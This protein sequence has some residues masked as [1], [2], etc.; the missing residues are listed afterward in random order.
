MA[1][2]YINDEVIKIKNKKNEIVLDCELYEIDYLTT[3]F[4][5]VQ[6]FL[7]FAYKSRAISKKNYESENKNIFIKYKGRKIVP[8]FEDDIIRKITSDLV[9]RN[10]KFIIDSDIFT[11][12]INELLVFLYNKD[13]EE[14]IYKFFENDVEV[15]SAFDERHSIE[16]FNFF[17]TYDD[18][19]MI[20]HYFKEKEKPYYL[21]EAP[22]ITMKQ[23]KKITKKE[24]SEILKD[25]K[26]V[27]ELV[28]MD[29]KNLHN[30]S[31]R[32]NFSEF[33]RRKISRHK[34]GM[35]DGY[36][37]LIKEWID[38]N[39]NRDD[40]VNRILS[41][42]KIESNKIETKIE[43]IE[44]VEIIEEDEYFYPEEIEMMKGTEDDVYNAKYHTIKHL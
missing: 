36:A 22:K 21:D 41:F 17:R 38:Y 26:V 43:N 30:P 2:L 44:N 32:P 11:K 25:S 3:T 20:H 4:K 14:A 7:E 13:N 40:I 24:I 27:K 31:Y 28:R 15:L 34:R 42:K 18:Y 8:I 23:G 16:I 9:K 19:R 1:Q 37:T 12:K 5:N 35:K 6:E 10:S 33:E 29:Y 39:I